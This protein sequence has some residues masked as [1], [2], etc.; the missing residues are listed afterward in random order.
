MKWTLIRTTEAA[1]DSPFPLPPKWSASF[2]RASGQVSTPEIVRHFAP[3]ARFCRSPKIFQNR[4][5]RRPRPPLRKNTPLVSDSLVASKKMR[6]R[7]SF[8]SNT[9]DDVLGRPPPPLLATL[10]LFATW[11]FSC[12][13]AKSPVFQGFATTPWWPIRWP[14]RR[15]MVA[16]KNK[17]AQNARST[18]QGCL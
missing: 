6:F 5:W 11:L 2:R 10:R 1:P 18:T 4:G 15:V 12:A 3:L 16:N 17:P 13:Y 8:I 14:I 7:K 9:W